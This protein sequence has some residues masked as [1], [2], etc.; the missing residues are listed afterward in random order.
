MF[1]MVTDIKSTFFKAILHASV[2]Y[3]TL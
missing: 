3:D 1:A 2:H